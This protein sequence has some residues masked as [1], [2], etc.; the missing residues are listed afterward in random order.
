MVLSSSMFWRCL[1]SHSG[2][3]RGVR[4][5]K[6][7]DLNAEIGPRLVVVEQQHQDLFLDTSSLWFFESPEEKNAPKAK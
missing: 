3:T 4:N 2:A 5:L 7:T 1:F 6:V